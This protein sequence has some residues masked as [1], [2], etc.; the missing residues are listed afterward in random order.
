M[1]GYRGSVRLRKTPFSPASPKSHTHTPR[2]SAA[3]SSAAHRARTATRTLISAASREQKGIRR[4]GSRTEYDLIA[5]LVLQAAP[6]G[7]GRPVGRSLRPSV[8][9][10]RDARW[11]QRPADG[12]SGSVQLCSRG[13]LRSFSGHFVKT[14]ARI[15]REEK[16]LFI[17]LSSFFFFPPPG[18]L[19]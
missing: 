1:Q 16:V 2:C 8:P 18:C 10:Q 6:R 5:L 17:F 11:Q 12:S 3:N 9:A 15:K 4:G 7:R 14:N 13:A 19:Y